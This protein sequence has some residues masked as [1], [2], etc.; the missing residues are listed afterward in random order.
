[1]DDQDDAPT[2][3]PPPPSPFE[4]RR[5][6]L[7]RCAHF[8]LG[9]APL[10][11]YKEFPDLLADALATEGVGID[12]LE[13]AA[14]AKI[15]TKVLRRWIAGIG[16]PHPRTQKEVVHALVLLLLQRNTRTRQDTHDHEE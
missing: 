15:E 8:Q 6:F 16:L 2:L 5:A 3:R 14:T 4:V 13:V 7:T 10:P 9:Q 12:I 1:M 11:M